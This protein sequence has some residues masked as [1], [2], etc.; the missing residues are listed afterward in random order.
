MSMF[1][2][3]FLNC[4]VA[5]E[6]KKGEN[7]STVATGFLVG[8]RSGS[9]DEKGFDL[10]SIFLI[11][12]RHVFR[13]KESV[14]LRFNKEE[15]FQRYE[16]SL[17]DGEGKYIW[18]AHP[19]PNVDVAVMGLNTE[20]LI[21]DGIKFQWFPEDLFA[22]VDR[23]KELGITQGDGI[24]VVGFPMGLAGEEK[25]YAILRGGIIARLDDEIIDKTNTFL[26]DAFIFPGNS[27]GPVI[28][29]PAISS[30]QG[31]QAINKNSISLSYS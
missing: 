11:T 14:W 30:I 15:K 21:E 3:Q 29:K 28:L 1:P 4:I 18:S 31:T 12:N 25:N 13:K 26:I 17:V 10:F 16:V 9:K 24:F 7:F 23:I 19:N 27:G 22:D 5:I 8:F 2:K 6:N 20:K